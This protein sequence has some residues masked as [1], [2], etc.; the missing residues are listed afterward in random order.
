MF[1]VTQRQ[2]RVRLLAAVV[3]VAAV[4]FAVT[5]PAAG[6]SSARGKER[7]RTTTIASRR[8]KIGMILV[9]PRGQKLYLFN[10]DRDGTSSCYGRC[11]WNWPP[12]RAFGRLVA[13][14]GSGVKQ[15]WLST[16]LRHDG[17]IRVTYDHHPLYVNAGHAKPG[18]LKG[19]HAHEFG[20]RWYAVPIGGRPPSRRGWTRTSSTHRRLTT[21][22][23]PSLPPQTDPPEGRGRTL[24]PY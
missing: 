17:V 9:G 3:L 24:E 10:R 8:T 22:L 6:A 1:G 7:V 16:T 4:G 5:W 20:G 14:R 2:V 11:A 15:Q 18:S 21:T 12:L 13:L 23:E 19:V